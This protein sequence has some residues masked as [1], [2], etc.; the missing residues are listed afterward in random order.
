MLTLFYLNVR[1]F[2]RASDLAWISC[3]KVGS[4]P[5]AA[6]QLTV[7]NPEFYLNILH[8]YSCIV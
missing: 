1:S 2:N 4:R 6:V 3:L 5:I 8:I 7:R